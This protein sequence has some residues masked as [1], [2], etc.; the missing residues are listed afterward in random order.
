MSAPEG[1]VLSR[2]DMIRLALVSAGAAALPAGR[3]VE[4]ALGG[5]IPPGDGPTGPDSPRVTPFARALSIPPRLTPTRTVAGVDHYDVFMRE[6]DLQILPGRKTRVFTYN[7]FL[8]GPTILAIRNR[9]AAVTFHNGLRVDTSVH[10]H[11]AYVAGDSDGHPADAIPPGTSKTNFYPNGV[12]VPEDDVASHTQWYHDHIHHQTATN[13]YRGLAGFYLLHDPN[14][15]AFRLPSG[16]QDVPICIQDKLFNRDNSLNYPFP[17]HGSGN[18]VVGDVILVNGVPQPKFAVARRKYRLRFLNGCN[19]RNLQLA[20]STGQSLVVIA[21]EAGFLERP[22]SLR[23]LFIVPAERYEAIVDFAQYPVGTSV[24]LQNQQGGERTTDVMRFDVTAD[25][26]DTSTV[27]DRLRTIEQIAEGQVSVRRHFRFHRDN[28][29]WVINGKTFDPNRIDAE[30][31]VGDVEVW[32][33]ENKSGGWLHPI[34]LHL[35]DFQVL[36]RNGKAPNPEESGWKETVSLGPN[37]T[38]RVI[39]HW[40]PIPDDGGIRG[41]FRTTYAFHCHNLEHED[42][43]MMLQFKVVE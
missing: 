2:R 17:R 7:G 35:L 43:D 34:H 25:A 11:G 8:P 37:E 9:P 30:P 29:E 32:T 23:S 22:V 15:D 14:E 27:P 13:V 40:P 19:A 16:A 3:L 5:G 10:N 36:D 41:R 4:I 21:S 28:G 33:F 26:V 38:I 31:R 20:L 6:A 39:M 18:G 12:D 1:P 24:V 42:H